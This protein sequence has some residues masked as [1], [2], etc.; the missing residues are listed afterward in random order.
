[1]C[2]PAMYVAIRRDSSPTGVTCE[3][4]PNFSDDDDDA[5][6]LRSAVAINTY[7]ITN[8]LLCFY[9]IVDKVIRQILRQR[10]K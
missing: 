7:L 3:E 8:N 5:D 1:M 2:R 9:H 10:K 6:C 4:E